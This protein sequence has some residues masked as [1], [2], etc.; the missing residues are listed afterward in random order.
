QR[1]QRV[2]D[3]WFV[4]DREKLLRDGVSNRIQARSGATCKND[5]SAR[6]VV[7]FV[8]AW[9]LPGYCVSIQFRYAP[10]VTSPTQALLSRYHCTVLRIPVANVS[11]GRQSRSRSIL[12]ASIA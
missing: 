8:P 6:A 4:I 9:T 2:I 11:N 7:H 1:A 10:L 3:H 5:S 12:R